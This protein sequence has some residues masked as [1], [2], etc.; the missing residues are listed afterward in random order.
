MKFDKTLVTSTWHSEQE[1]VLDNHSPRA[2]FVFGYGMI[3]LPDV[4]CRESKLSQGD[5]RNWWAG[6]TSTL[7]FALGTME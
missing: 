6:L 4:R 7:S 2:L 5:M 1:R 3:L